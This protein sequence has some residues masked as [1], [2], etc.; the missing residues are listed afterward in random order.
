MSYIA[1]TEDSLTTLQ[2]SKQRMLLFLTGVDPEMNLTVEKYL[3]G[4]GFGKFGLP[5]EFRF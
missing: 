1:C 2:L 3:K 5:G 4:P